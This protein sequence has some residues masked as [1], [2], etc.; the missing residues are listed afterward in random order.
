MLFRFERHYLFQ[1]ARYILVFTSGAASIIKK[2][3]RDEHNTKLLVVK[4]KL[5]QEVG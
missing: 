3:G 1:A 2:I 4:F 5:G